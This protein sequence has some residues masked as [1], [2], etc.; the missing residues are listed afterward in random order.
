M[1][2]KLMYSASV[3]AALLIATTAGTALAQGSMKKALDRAIEKS[4][5]K[6]TA[7]PAAPESQSPAKTDAEP[8]AKTEG[9]PESSTAPAPAATPAKAAARPKPAWVDGGCDDFLAYTGLDIMCASGMSRTTSNL[10]LCR[11]SAMSEARSLL[12]RT[13]VGHVQTAMNNAG[14][15]PNKDVV[16]ETTSV[17]KSD[18]TKVIESKVKLSLSGLTVGASWVSTEEGCHTIVIMDRWSF[19]NTVFAACGSVAKDK[20]KIEEIAGEVWNAAIM[21]K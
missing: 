11:V 16:D 15:A 8:E 4:P 14:C 12:S 13:V 5:S 18:G 17:T 10:N 9:Q 20:K 6:T 19:V 1:K 2:R 21:K 3:A 7:T